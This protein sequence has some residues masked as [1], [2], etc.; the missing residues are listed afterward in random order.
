[1]SGTFLI[2]LKA[3]VWKNVRLKVRNRRQL[4][5]EMLYPV[6][7]TTL[8]C[9]INLASKPTHF[10]AE[11]LSSHPAYDASKRPEGSIPIEPFQLA[12]AVTGGDKTTAYDTMNRVLS[13]LDDT[14]FQDRPNWMLG[15]LWPPEY[16]AGTQLVPFD[17][18]DA[19]LTHYRSNASFRNTLWA[20]VELNMSSTDYSYVIRMKQNSDQ[21]P[22]PDTPN[23]NPMQATVP[24]NNELVFPDAQCRLASFEKQEGVCDVGLYWN[25]GF[26][27]L[28]S[29]LDSAL[30]STGQTRS[31]ASR[32]S[33]D[34]SVSSS[35]SDGDSDSSSGSSSDSAD[36][37]GTKEAKPGVADA[38]GDADTT[39]VARGGGATDGSLVYAIQ[40]A[41]L[42]KFIL[43][44]SGPLRPIAIMMII[45][46][47]APWVQYLMTHIV[48]EKEHG[49]KEAMYLMGMR[50]DSFWFSWFVTYALMTVTPC[51][52]MTVIMNQMGLFLNADQ[53]LICLILYLFGLSLVGMGMFLAN[54]FSIAK[55]A[56]L[57]GM[58][59]TTIFSLAIFGIADITST[60]LKWGIS[61]ASPLA[62]SLALQHAL[63]IEANVGMTWQNFGD[64]VDGFS[65][66]NATFMLVV[67]IVLYVSLVSRTCRTVSTL[68]CQTP[69]ARRSA[70]VLY[71]LHVCC[72]WRV[73]HP[74]LHSKQRRLLSH[75]RSVISLN[76]SPL[77][78]HANTLLHLPERARC[79][80]HQRARC[81][82]H[83]K[84]ER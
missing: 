26:L 53:T 43:D 12:Y 38:G 34:G 51:I 72:M 56:G 82:S 58:L 25:S 63:L 78:A 31:R 27:A 18:A 2:Q 5:T 48:N 21:H 52:A 79:G 54:F 81:G 22:A 9:S 50:L 14:F 75:A 24:G 4:L 28:Q 64:T 73:S 49:I 10:D 32:A 23:T 66:A 37:E 20:G 30:C 42:E 41:P 70:C 29:A 40:E 71:V 76:M 35:D 17:S 62:A 60:G 7:F 68:P 15:P 36:D 80:S 46:G 59:S 77:H 84:K 6:I 61:L 55:T 8:V 19:M 44:R 45:M 74:K 1:M 65:A 47:F 3:L 57:V 11:P 33:R 16:Q 69:D 83:Q 13:T 39:P 67:D